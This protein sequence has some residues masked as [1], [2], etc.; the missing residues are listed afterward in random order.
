MVRFQHLKF[1][2]ISSFLLLYLNF[3]NANGFLLDQ[4][5][6]FPQFND[7]RMLTCI[8]VNRDYLFDLMLYLRPQI[9]NAIVL[10][11]S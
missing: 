8:F 7:V 2:V 5:M 4:F 1:T 3:S 9:F 11:R 6:F 10:Y